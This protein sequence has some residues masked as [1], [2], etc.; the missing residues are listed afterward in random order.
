VIGKGFWGLGDLYGSFVSLIFGVGTELHFGD[1][2]NE[3]Q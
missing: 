2:E 1:V 3:V